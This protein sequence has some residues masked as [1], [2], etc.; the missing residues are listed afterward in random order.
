MTSQIKWYLNYLSFKIMKRDEKLK[1]FF[2]I[3][4]PLYW[5]WVIIEFINRNVFKNK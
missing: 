5:G 2:I 1:V 3:T 4:N